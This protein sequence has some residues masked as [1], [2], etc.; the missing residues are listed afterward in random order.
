MVTIIRFVKKNSIIS[1]IK[2]FTASYNKKKLKNM[3]F[4]NNDFLVWS[5]WNKKYNTENKSKIHIGTNDKKFI[6]Y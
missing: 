2:P 1:T 5:N 4:F 3:F 6:N